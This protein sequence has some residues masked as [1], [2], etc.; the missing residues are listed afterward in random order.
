MKTTWIITSALETTVGVYDT[1]ARILQ[2]HETINSIQK[3]YPDANIVLVEGGLRIPEHPLYDR[4]KARC[5]VTLNMT[6]N[7]Q[8]KHLQENF[9]SKIENR[10][11][12]GGATGITKSVAELT[13]MASVLDALKNHPDMA[14]ALD[15]Q[16]IFKISGRYQLSPLFE[17]AVYEADAVKGH[18]VFRQRDPSW[19]TDALQALG[20]EYG[21]SSRLWSFDVNQLDD[22]IERFDNMIED[23]LSI[24]QTH[25]VD[26]EH[27]LFKH[28]SE[29]EPVEL[30]H[31]HLYGSIA[32]TGT[33][34]YD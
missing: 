24:T 27:L 34:I 33:V 30:E 7:D 8:I 15:A 25:Y 6:G 3:Y 18:Y 22:V 31:T 5:N 19:M 10:N 23:C 20:T 17:P 11:E 32:P 28:M 13:L 9:L 2:T 12:M 4:L 21:Y 16:R 26:M 29:T 14:P 1:T